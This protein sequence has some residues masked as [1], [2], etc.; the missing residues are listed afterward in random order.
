M[1]EYL[2]KLGLMN[3]RDDQNRTWKDGIEFPA[4]DLNSLKNKKGRSHKRTTK[5][6]FD[7]SPKS[8][9]H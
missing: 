6:V 9:D 2:E 7:S 4:P 5:K 8:T 1:H 3:S